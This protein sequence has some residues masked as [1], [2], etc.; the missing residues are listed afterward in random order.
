MTCMDN[1]KKIKFPLVLNPFYIY[2]IIWM[3]V[4]FIRSL[5]INHIY[6]ATPVNLWIFIFLTIILSLFFGYV[7]H[8]IILKNAS[9][10]TFEITGNYPAYFLATVCVLGII[11]SI[12]YSRNLPILSTIRGDAQSYREFG[13]PT[14]TPLIICCALALNAIT[15]VKLFYGKE[16]RVHNLIILL[17]C[18]VIF[19]LTF[20]RGALIICVASS[21]FIAISRTRFGFKKIIGTIIFVLIFAFVFNIFGNIRQQSAWNDSSYI[22]GLAKFD[23]NYSWLSNFSWGIIYLD[24]PLGNVAYNMENVSYINDIDGFI[25]QLIPDL[26]SKRIF[27]GYDSQLVLACPGLNVAS[28]Y[29]GGYKFFGLFGMGIQFILM[30][31][32]IFILAAIS[33][34]RTETLL[35]VSVYLTILS[36]MTFF[37]NVFVYSG[38]SFAVLVIL[39]FDFIRYPSPKHVS[40]SINEKQTI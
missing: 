40:L 12:I 21:F 6:P 33:R 24:S 38:F 29:E 34:R 22:M 10:T 8:Q 37:S 19:L 20:S 16:K 17:I 39:I 36:A 30:S 26:I 32:I 2:A 5:N 14:V 31:M 25:S 15:S 23:E 1:A 7:Y 28:M 35:A 27:S 13:I 3:I 18:Y 11:A 4:L 9:K